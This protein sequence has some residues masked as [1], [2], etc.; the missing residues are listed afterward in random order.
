MIFYDSF[1]SFFLQKI[2]TNYKITLAPHKKVLHAFRSPGMHGYKS[3]I[4]KSRSHVW[5][6]GCETNDD[7]LSGYECNE[8][9]VCYDINECEDENLICYLNICINTIGSFYCRKFH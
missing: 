4:R 7:C 6:K 3:L 5:L 1:L 2:L 9:G 8:N